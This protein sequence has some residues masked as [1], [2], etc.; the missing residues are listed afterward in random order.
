VGKRVT[1]STA[2]LTISA[3]IS[4]QI[5]DGSEV[6]ERHATPRKAL[7]AVRDTNKSRKGY[8]NLLL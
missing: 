1:K 8:S 3:R 6:G 2:F 7:V 4:A 5:D